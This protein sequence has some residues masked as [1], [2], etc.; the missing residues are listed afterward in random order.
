MGADSLWHW[1]IV[2]IIVPLLFGRGRVSDLMGDVAR[3]IKEFKRAMSDDENDS[4]TASPN[5]EPIEKKDDAQTPTSGRLGAPGGD[6]T[7]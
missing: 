7:S 1:I 2:I 4:R 5:P 3:G 6:Q